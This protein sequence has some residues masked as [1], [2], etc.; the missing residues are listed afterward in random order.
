M[1]NPTH[2]VT[3]YYGETGQQKMFFDNDYLSRENKKF[4]LKRL[5]RDIQHDLM[6]TGIKIEE[7][8]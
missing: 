3:F 5:C 8:K 1:K 4:S 7:I 6:A 2:Q